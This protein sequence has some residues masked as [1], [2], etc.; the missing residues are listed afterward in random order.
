MTFGIVHCSFL[1]ERFLYCYAL[2]FIPL[3]TL[4]FI[5]IHMITA[6]KKH[7]KRN[8]TPYYEIDCGPLILWYTCVWEM[9]SIL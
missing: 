3:Y 7:L 8:K 1:R 9:I 4:P 5:F 2:N 6:N